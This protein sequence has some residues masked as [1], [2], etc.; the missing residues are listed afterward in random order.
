MGEIEPTKYDDLT[1]F[2]EA[3]QC[4]GFSDKQQNLIYKVIAAILHGGNIDF[5]K[6]D[7]EGSTISNK[8]DLNLSTFCELLGEK[9]E[10]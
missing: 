6:D 2:N 3:M 1:K 8:S 7:K 5:V 9:K 4:L 10:F